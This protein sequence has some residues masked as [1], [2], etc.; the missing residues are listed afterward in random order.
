[1]NTA[2]AVDSG[3]MWTEPSVYTETW[4]AWSS[5]VIPLNI[6]FV[7]GRSAKVSDLFK[8]NDSTWMIASFQEGIVAVIGDSE[9]WRVN[10]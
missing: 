10:S 5:A 7:L 1:M 8:G 6:W 2:H 3:V 9:H 4:L